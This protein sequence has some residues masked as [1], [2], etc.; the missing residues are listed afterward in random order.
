MT[1]H[2]DTEIRRYTDGEALTQHR[3]EQHYAN[4]VEQR[5]TR[6]QSPRQPKDHRRSMRAPINIEIAGEEFEI[7]GRAPS[8]IPTMFALRKGDFEQVMKDLIGEDGLTRVVENLAD[9]DGYSSFDDLNDIVERIY[10]KA[11]SKNS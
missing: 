8:N 3:D 10:E 1:D 5:S 11:G 7:D 9:E 6:E 4:Q 2:R